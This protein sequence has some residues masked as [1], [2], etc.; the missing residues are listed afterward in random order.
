MNNTVHTSTLSQCRRISNIR[1]Q[2]SGPFYRTFRGE[3]LRENFFDR[4]VYRSPRSKITHLK[5]TKGAYCEIITTPT[6]ID[7]PS[8]IENQALC[9]RKEDAVL[10]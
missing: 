7:R 1:Q 4:D 10:D 2:S 9:R 6:K 3:C 8:A 5:A